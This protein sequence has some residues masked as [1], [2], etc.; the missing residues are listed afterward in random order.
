LTA[1]EAV[2]PA[3]PGRFVGLDR[4]KGLALWAM[5]LHH[6]LMWMVGDARSLLGGDDGM[7]VTDLAAPMFAVSAGAGAALLARRLREGGGPGMARM[8]GRW[9]TIGAW[10]VALGAAIDHDVDG[11]GVLETLAVGGVLITVLARRAAVPAWSWASAA[12]VLTVTS[13]W[14]IDAAA[15]AGGWWELVLGSRFPL[16]SYLAMGLAGA[17]V[18]T[19]LGGEEG[20]RRLDGVALAAVVATVVLAWTAGGDYGVWPADRHPGGPA[21]I[22]PGVVATVVTWAVLAHLRP[23]LITRG[24]ERAGRRTLLVYVLHYALRVVLDLGGWWAELDG[25][26]W[27]AAAVALAAVMATLSAL[28]APR[29]RRVARTAP[30]EDRAQAL[31]PSR[32]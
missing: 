21:F 14:V 3:A 19:H 29:R 24:M 23:G 27:T 4:L 9:A 2:A 32:A 25:P 1:L 12:G 17:A 7:A 30:I 18:V 20:R 13:P 31:A 6:A 28:P 16:L 11:I 15:A 5:L 10:G 22:V 26:G 8:V